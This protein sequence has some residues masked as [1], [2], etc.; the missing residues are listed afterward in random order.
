[1]RAIRMVVVLVALSSLL[2]GCQW[3][4]HVLCDSP[5]NPEGQV[6]VFLGHERKHSSVA[7]RVIAKPAV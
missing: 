3:L 5:L 1:M 7:S 2:S 6:A 4:C